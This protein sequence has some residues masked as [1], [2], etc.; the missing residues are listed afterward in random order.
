MTLL[1]TASA[2]K[3]D[4]TAEPLLI[5]LCG[6]RDHSWQLCSEGEYSCGSS[7]Q[8]EIRLNISGIEAAH[9]RLIYRGGQLLVRRGRGRIW[10]HE[11]PVAGEARICECDVVSLGGVALRFEGV[12][13]AWVR[14]GR[15]IDKNP[16]AE[17]LEPATPIV[18]FI[19]NSGVSFSRL[20]SLFA[21]ESARLAGTESRG[22]LQHSAPARENAHAANHEIEI[23][24]R[25]REHELQKSEATISRILDEL[26]QTRRK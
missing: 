1:L 10:V 12:V 11:L 25:R 16:A 8:D 23:S 9:C 5:S 19:G 20:A 26:E 2:N 22:P 13:T 4:Q 18:Q 15:R 21:A 6:S 3:A 24:L 7:Q 14:S 17:S